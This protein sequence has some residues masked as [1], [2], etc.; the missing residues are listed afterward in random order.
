MYRPLDYLKSDC[1]NQF[2]KV[3]FFSIASDKQF[4]YE[5]NDDLL[6]NQSRDILNS[7]GE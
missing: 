6:V 5:I 7:M 2:I 1:F 3:K 4:I